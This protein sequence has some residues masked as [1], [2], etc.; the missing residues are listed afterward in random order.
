MKSRLRK[1]EGLTYNEIVS[2]IKKVL[3]NIPIE[4]YKNLIIGAYQ[5]NE[6][7]TKTKISR[8]KELKNYL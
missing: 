4:Y 1:L 6:N 3:S 7:Y 8:K 5:R 2:N